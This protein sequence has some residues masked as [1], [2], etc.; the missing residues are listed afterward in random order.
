M[1]LLL[2]ILARL[3]S[4]IQ[5]KNLKKVE[6]FT[7]KVVPVDVGGCFSVGVDDVRTTRREIILGK[8]FLPPNKNEPDEA[9]LVTEND[10][11]AA[12]GLANAPGRG[13]VSD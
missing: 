10:E 4:N 3:E 2:K 9:E 1:I 13:L 7:S 5:G 8:K 11:A 6:K 12:A